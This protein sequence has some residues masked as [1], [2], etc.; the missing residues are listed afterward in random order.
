MKTDQEMIARLIDGELSARERSEFLKSLDDKESVA[1]RSLA[2]GFVERQVLTDALR[3]REAKSGKVIA[4]Q[5]ED[6]K[7]PR[8]REWRFT[9]AALLALGLGLGLGALGPKLF[10]GV[11]PT[12]ALAHDPLVEEGMQGMGDEVV[13]A[14]LMKRG[15]IS[16]DFKDGSKLIVP[17]SHA[18]TQNR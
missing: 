10:D 4:F 11:E 17:I 1:W 6:E 15:Y 2:L 9:G 16:A 14:P 7:K 8:K 12:P 13:S 18:I 3:T 5:A